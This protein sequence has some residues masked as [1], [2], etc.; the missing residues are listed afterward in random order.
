MQEILRVYRDLKGVQVLDDQ[1]KELFPKDKAKWLE[2]SAVTR[3][4]IIAEMRR[5]KSFSDSNPADGIQEAIK[6]YY[7]EDKKISLYVLAD[8]FN[9]E[10][11]QKIVDAVDL[12]NRPNDAGRRRV[13]IHGIGFPHSRAMT[14][15]SMRRFPALMRALAER[16]DGTFI[17]LSNVPTCEI[18][19]VIN[20]E[21]TCVGGN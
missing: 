19:V 6:N 13:R 12:V 17:G 10:S 2:D 5:W 4:K 3:K 11:I 7:D 1:G 18:P 15:E 16:N 21:L 20:G 8:D 14:T 9:G